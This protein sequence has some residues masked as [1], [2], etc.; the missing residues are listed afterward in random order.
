MKTILFLALALLNSFS[1]KS[2]DIT[3]RWSGILK[4]QGIQLRLVFHISKTDAGYSSTMDS[5][6]QGA[7]GIPTSSTDVENSNLKITAPNLGIEYEGILGHYSITGAFKQRGQSLPLNLSKFFVS[8][9]P[10]QIS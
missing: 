1:M 5:P 4:V 10:A 3:R 9:I 7:I 2:Q 6:D 8:I